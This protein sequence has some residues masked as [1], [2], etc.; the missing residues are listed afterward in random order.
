VEE[1]RSSASC[2]VEA[3]LDNDDEEPH[4]AVEE[5]EEIAALR[6]VRVD[7]F[8]LL[9]FTIMPRTLCYVIP[10]NKINDAS[11]RAP[12]VVSLLCSSRW[13]KQSQRQSTKAHN[14]YLLLTSARA[15]TCVI[16]EGIDSDGGKARGEDAKICRAELGSMESATR[17]VR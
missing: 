14:T 9:G 12:Q 10:A 1:R 5:G 4:T 2:Q 16:A 7:R 3:S 8:L 15:R 6:F 11:A 13:P 17:Q